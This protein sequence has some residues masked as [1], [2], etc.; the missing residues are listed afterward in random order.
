MGAVIA[1]VS[2]KGGM[3]KTA[4]CAAAATTLA[5]DGQRVL[6]IDCDDGMGDLEHYLALGQ[7]PALTYPEICTGAYPLTRA[8]AHPAFGRLRFLA[9]PA[10][11]HRT[12]EEAFAALLRRA[13]QDFDY[14]LLDSPRFS[15]AADQWILVTHADPAAIRGAR[16]RADALELAGAGNVRLIVNGVD[17]RKMAALGLTVDDVMDQ[18]GTPLLGIVPWHEAVTLAPKEEKPLL[19][20]TKKGAAAAMQRISR[21]MQG[22]NVRI[23]SRVI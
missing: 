18:V 16:R 15:V 9:A 19:S 11:A 17:G 22:L 3:G 8:A 7:T 6:C 5:S 14:I 10:G 20:Y 21:R 13:K 1:F 2:G 4:L 12:D 23:P